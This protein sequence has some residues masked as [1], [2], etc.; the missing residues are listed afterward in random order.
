MN[1][2]DKLL[3]KTKVFI[4]FVSLPISLGINQ[5][6]IHKC[7]VKGDKNVYTNQH[8]SQQAHLNMCTVNA[9]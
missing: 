6:Y 9:Q 5:K 4:L 7:P 8:I 3:N 1:A 2:T